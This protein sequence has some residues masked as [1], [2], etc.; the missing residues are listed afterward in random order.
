MAFYRTSFSLWFVLTLGIFSVLVSPK[1]TESE[2]EIEHLPLLLEVEEVCFSFSVFPVFP[3]TGE[4]VEAKETV[5]L[6]VA[7]STSSQK[8][9]LG[10]WIRQSPRMTPTIKV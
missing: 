5:L 1:A 3:G 10:K 2:C 6:G 7:I 9:S 4:G 8:G